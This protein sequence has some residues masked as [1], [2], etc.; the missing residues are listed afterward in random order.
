[1]VVIKLSLAF[2]LLLT[3]LSLKLL[4]SLSGQPFNELIVVDDE[5]DD[6]EDDKGGGVVDVDRLLL[7]WWLRWWL[8][9]WWLYSPVIKVVDNLDPNEIGLKLPFNLPLRVNS[10]MIKLLSL[11]EI[12]EDDEDVVEDEIKLLL[13]LLLFTWL[14]V[15]DDEEDEDEDEV[16]VI[17]VIVDDPVDDK[18]KDKGEEDEGEDVEIIVTGIGDVGDTTFLLD[19]WWWW[20]VIVG[21]TII[22]VKH[23]PKVLTQSTVDS[24]FCELIVDD[25]DKLE[26]GGFVD[27]DKSRLMLNDNF[28]GDLGDDLEIE[29][30]ELELIKLL[31]PV[32]ETLLLLLAIVLFVINSLWSINEWSLPLEHK[33][34]SVWFSIIDEEKVG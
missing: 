23:L 2:W 21:V 34:S 7:L 15:V 26:L 32:V 18:D 13:L 17:V 24:E 19:C 31:G 30:L 9:T 10:S 6:D 20:F 1:M 25:K 8:L 3:D 16:E 12:E 4:A 5:S 28:G 22:D 11:A 14:S 33:S 27:L 29:M